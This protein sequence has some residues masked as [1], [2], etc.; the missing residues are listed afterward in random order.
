MYLCVNNMYFHFIQI[1][2]KNFG[3]IMKEKYVATSICSIFLAHL[4]I[5]VIIM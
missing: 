2:K 3:K 5:M 1:I 4:N